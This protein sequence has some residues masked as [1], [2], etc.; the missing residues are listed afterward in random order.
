MIRRPPR[1]TLFPYTTLFRSI[2]R[3]NSFRIFSLTRDLGRRR[4][5]G[6][7]RLRF[8]A[9]GAPRARA[10]PGTAPHPPGRAREAA[11][12]VL[13]PLPAPARRLPGPQGQPDRVGLVGG[14]L[15]R[16]PTR[17]DEARPRGPDPRAPPRLRR[18]S[19]AYGPAP[20]LERTRGK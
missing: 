4:E 10:A 13:V 3:K 15:P 19:A 20:S 12:R 6:G 11:R 8:A 9:S 16:G 1:S 18:P 2:S 14:P 5:P 17:K 7:R